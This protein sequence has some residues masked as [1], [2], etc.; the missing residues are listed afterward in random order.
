MLAGYQDIWW[1]SLLGILSPRA[2][3]YV[4]RDM[5]RNLSGTIGQTAKETAS[6]TAAQQ[7]SLSSLA[8]VVLDNVSSINCFPIS[9]HLYV[10][11]LYRINLLNSE[12]STMGK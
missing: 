12:V 1:Q 4:N 2:G 7:T 11:L 6:S 3:I 9:I 8:H 5:L 10:C